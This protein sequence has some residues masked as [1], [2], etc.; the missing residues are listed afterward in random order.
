MRMTR[1]SRRNMMKSSHRDRCIKQGIG[2]LLIAGTC[3]NGIA[4]AETVVDIDTPVSGTVFGNGTGINNTT[5]PDKDGNIYGSISDYNVNLLPGAE[6]EG[7]IGAFGGDWKHVSDFENNTIR[8]VEATIIPHSHYYGGIKGAFILGYGDAKDNNVS[9]SKFEDKN[10]SSGY[11][12][13]GA[14]HYGGGGISSNNMVALDNVTIGE[15]NHTVDI[16]GAYISVYGKGDGNAYAYALD[17]GVIIRDSKID[18]GI[19]GGAAYGTGAVLVGISET[20]IPVSRAE[21]KADRNNVLLNNSRIEGDVIGGGVSDDFYSITNDYTVVTTSDENN[22]RIENNSYTERITGGSASSSKGNSRANSNVVTVDNSAVKYFIDGGVARGTGEICADNNKIYIVNNS[23]VNNG[24]DVGSARADLYN[25][26]S[27]K[28]SS[29]KNY[30]FIDSSIVKEGTIRGGYTFLDMATGANGVNSSVIM[31]SSNN[32]IIL[33]GGEVRDIEG[34]VAV[35]HF[36][37]SD[38][39]TSASIVV[40]ANGNKITINDGKVDWGI[41]GGKVESNNYPNVT[42]EAKDNTVTWKN[43]I[44]N[45]FITGDLIYSNNDGEMAYS[46]DSTSNSTFNFYASES[47]S[48][49]TI[50]GIDN[51]KNYNFYLDNTVSPNGTL[52]TVQTPVDLTKSNVGVA[53]TSD[54]KFEVGDSITLLATPDLKTSPD[55]KNDTSHMDLDPE[56]IHRMIGENIYDIFDFYLENDGFNLKATLGNKSENPKLESISASRQPLIHLLDDH[57]DVVDMAYEFSL[58]H[59]EPVGFY[60]FNYAKVST[61]DVDMQGNS[62]VFGSAFTKGE[63]DTITQGPF[64]EYGDSSF[65]GHK[66]YDSGLVDDSGKVKKYGA[67]YLYRKVI[68]KRHHLDAYVRTGRISHDYSSDI[69]RIGSLGYKDES[70]YY[71]AH[72]GYG[73]FFQIDPYT[74][75]DVYGKYFYKNIAGSDSTAYINGYDAID[76]E[77]DSLTSHKLRIGSKLTVQR[78]NKRTWYAD[79]AIEHELSKTQKSYMGGHSIS[80]ESRSDTT[81]VLE[82]GYKHV[83]GP[84]DSLVFTADV[85]GYVGSRSGF[86]GSIGISF[87]F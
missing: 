44:V 31:D 17:N 86:G 77:F 55:L 84:N 22:I 76:T 14:Y 12:I 7:V 13:S 70:M 28:L 33:D 66:F 83:F 24:V 8:G 71:A 62:M 40:R 78:D 1:K 81:G 11:D 34:G 45:G 32:E 69:A 79:L 48:N 9:L 87:N 20:E 35:E 72:L 27:V 82:V 65:I 67:G 6:V 5:P 50:M 51:F 64:I 58:G 18:G 53:M 85:C 23:I 36:N 43:G 41:I 37:S 10:L 75:L 3:F 26:K 74:K 25:N 59:D 47:N 4:E 39:S 56:P 54:N 30:A 15:Y 29:S 61:N 16:R 63:K 80:N 60:D 52:I 73:Q 38:L 49:K 42:Y 19:S 21:L 46:W 2:A 57:V 68:D